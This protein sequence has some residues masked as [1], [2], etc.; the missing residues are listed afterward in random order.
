MFLSD[1]FTGFFDHHYLLKEATH[2][3]DFFHSNSCEGKIACNT[4]TIGWVW[5]GV[6][7][8]AQTWLDLIGVNLVGLCLV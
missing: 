5:P 3:L 8:H 7:S 2:V 1:K 4:T 6:P